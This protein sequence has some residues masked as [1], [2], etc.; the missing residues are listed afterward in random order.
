ML[1]KHPIDIDSLPATTGVYIMRDA[2]GKPVYVGK[3]RNIRARVRSYFSLGN[4]DTRV[5]IPHLHEVVRD[6][7]FVITKTER[8]ALLLE[9]SFIKQHKPKFNI[10][11]K[12]DKTYASL[13]L[14]IKERFPKLVFT[15]RINDDDAVYLGPFA[16]GSALRQVKRLI[17]KLFP[18][19][20]CSE[21]KFKRYSD[22][23]CL[24]YYMKLC[25]APCAG[26]VDESEYKE[27]V[28]AARQFMKGNKKELIRILEANMHKASE[29]MRYEDAA[30]YRDQIKLLQ[31]NMDVDRIISSSFIDRDI[32]GYFRED[33]EYTFIVLHSR[34]G[35]V[36]DKSEFFVKTPNRDE[37]VVLEEFI[38][39]LYQSGR[40]IPKEILLPKSIQ[41]EDVYSGLFSEFKG[42]KVRLVVPKR[43]QKLKLIQMASENA[44][45]SHKKRRAALSDLRAVLENIQ[46]ILSLKRFPKTIECVDISNIQ[47]TFPVAS[48]VR[49]KDG[50]PDKSGYRRYRITSVRGQDDFASIKEAVYR[51]IK[52][53]NQD[54][55][56][57]PDLFVIDGGRG[58]LSS[59]LEVFKE[60]GLH[61]E[62]DIISIAKG[63]S[64]EELD[65]IYTVVSDDPYVLNDNKEEIHLLMRIRDE[66]HRFAVSYHRKLRKKS[67]FASELD[68]IVGVGKK[69]KLALLKRF[70][71]IE[72]VRKASL[73]DLYSVPGMDK[74]TARRIKD[75]LT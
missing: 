54:G 51:R 36:V 43:G 62:I 39:R 5:Q 65:K 71:S 50:M 58:Q 42:K 13:K 46:R 2:E 73:E 34:E 53:M 37:C 48:I 7:D 9:N 25:C 3:A 72:G 22:R 49:F 30:H 63:N 44:L 31:K 56:E 68:S 52:R 57:L 4:G 41:N 69:R 33:N 16:S 55:W 59:T 60:E 21:G 67:A 64:Y 19:R 10:R 45:E 74:K 20:D 18:V 40:F 66:A 70:G 35:Q 38:A 15:R 75:A 28:N 47:G 17:H 27:V 6:I 14:T 1:I 61:Q 26:M 23:P 8:E 11:L 24:N 12:D 29:E 32:I